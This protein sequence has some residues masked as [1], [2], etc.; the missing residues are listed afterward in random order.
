MG[1]QH[2]LID[3]AIATD[4]I[5]DWLDKGNFD[6]VPTFGLGIGYRH[7]DHLRFD[8]TGEYRGKASFSALDY[9]DV[10]TDRGAATTAPTTTPPR[11]P[12]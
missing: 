10:D 9:Y 7:N 1:S 6:A 4:D 3:E 8:L 12:S 5:F 2:P 11:S